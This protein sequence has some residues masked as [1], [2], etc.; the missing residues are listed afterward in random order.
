[1]WLFVLFN[2][3]SIVVIAGVAALAPRRSTTE[4]LAV[5][6]VSGTIQLI[7]MNTIVIPPAKHRG[8]TV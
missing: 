1:M 6:I 7:A 3:K 8:V 4:L 5:V 2:A